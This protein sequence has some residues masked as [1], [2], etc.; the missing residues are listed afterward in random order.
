[1]YD[2]DG[3]NDESDARLGEERRRLLLRIDGVERVVGRMRRDTC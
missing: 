1:V 2:H 3:V